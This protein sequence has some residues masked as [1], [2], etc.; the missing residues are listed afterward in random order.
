MDVLNKQEVIMA[1]TFLHGLSVLTYGH[2]IYQFYSNKN[3]TLRQK[4]WGILPRAIGVIVESSI[5]GKIEGLHI[6]QKIS[7]GINGV[8]IPLC[9]IE[10][11]EESYEDAF[12]TVLSNLARLGADRDSAMLVTS[13]I[14]KRQIFKK[15][16]TETVEKIYNY[17]TWTR[18]S[19]SNPERVSERI[20]E[21]KA[22]FLK[23]LE[24]QENQL[25][26]VK[27]TLQDYQNIMNNATAESFGSIP[28]CYRNRPEFTKRKCKISKEPV[29][30]A[31]V[32]KEISLPIYYEC[33]NLSGWYKHE[34]RPPPA[35]PKSIPFNRDVIVVDKAETNQI[36]EDLQKA[37]DQTQ[38]NPEE[39]EAIKIGFLSVQEVLKNF[40][41]H[42]TK[43]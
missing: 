20:Q 22:K 15:Q 11:K 41:L 39:L 34:R 12:C 19:L 24:T 42:K 43:D 32:I 26:I 3:L 4:I 31:V 16:Y 18:I 6:L 25:G 33:D 14:D 2:S 40:L 37:L 17:Y 27:E 35:W 28:Y 23:Y 1:A 29:R 38:N 7:P 21:E 36:T 5:L 13:L 8:M 30:E 10:A 9:N